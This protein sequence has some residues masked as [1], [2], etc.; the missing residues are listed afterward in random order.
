MAGTVPHTYLG[1]YPARA[2]H[3]YSAIAQRNFRMVDVE[4]A[5][6]PTMIERH[7]G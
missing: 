3:D 6:R 1:V 4:R 5:G 2:A 7:P